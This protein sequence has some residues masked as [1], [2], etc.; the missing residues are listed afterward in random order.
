MAK[1]EL[2]TTNFDK[3]VT[4]LVL[5][6]LEENLRNK[7]VYMHPGAYVPGSIIPGTNLIRHIAIGDLSVTTNANVETPSTTPWLAE[8]SPASEEALSISYEEYSA[9]QAG[10]L[11]AITDLALA[12]SPFSLFQVAAE[13]IAENA[14]QTMDLYIGNEL[15]AG[16][17]RVQYIG[18]VT[19]RLTTKS[20]DVMT[21]A[22]IRKAVTTLKA[23][24]VPTFP[25]GTYHAF[26]NPRV[27]YDLQG[28]TATGGWLDTSK[29]A[30]PDGFLTGEI[31]RY[32]GVRFIET[33][34][35]NEFDLAGT[36]TTVALA[37][38]AAADDIVDTGSAHGFAVNDPIHFVTLTGG[39]GVSVGTTY[40]VIAANLGAQTFQFST[41]VGGGAVNF[42]TDMTAGT[43]GKA[44]DVMSTFV[45]GP[46]CFAFGDLQSTRAYMVSPGGD[47]SDPLAQKALVGWKGAWGA[48][49]LEAAG[50]RYVRIESG[51]T[52]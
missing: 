26:I 19:S 40:Y 25:D 30:Y 20:S 3:T 7:T 39:A 8:G 24:N 10:R 35:A 15:H 51:V 9:Y 36:N 14:R 42:T 1:L 34:V 6:R 17:A 47:H 29:Y 13:R 23:A 28:D 52:V 16:T 49:L 4:A 22:A 48:R 21:G 45:T 11:I 37:T 32:M 38:S 2:A 27:T 31:G 12:E 33:N 5:R 46:D 44:V 43:V 50:A 41:T 18:A